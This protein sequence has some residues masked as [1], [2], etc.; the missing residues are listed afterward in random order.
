M[1]KLLKKIIISLLGKRKRVLPIIG[2]I[3][4]GLKIYASPYNQLSLIIG[5]YEKDTQKTIAKFV[6]KG[7][8]VL[9]VGA[10]IG[11]FTLSLSKIVGDTGQVYSFEAIPDTATELQKNCTLN[12]LTNVRIF[13]NAV[14]SK[15]DEVSF[16]IP[17]GGSNHAMASMIWHKKDSSAKKV[18]CQSIVLDN[19]PNTKNLHPQFIKIDVEGAEALVLKSMN[20]IIQKSAPIIFIE[21]SGIG[22]KGSWDILKEFEYSCFKATD[23]NTEI[24]SFEDYKHSDFLWK[25]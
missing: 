15:E 23:L 5:S 13:N 24:T 8:T 4:K 3:N 19:F 17:E 20:S 7:D 2:G 18:I 10:N 11:Y 14:S 9:D 1:R 6:K 12:H 16:L 21:C 25:K 22:R